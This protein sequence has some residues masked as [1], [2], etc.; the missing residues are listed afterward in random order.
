MSSRL[1]F[2]ALS[3]VV[4]LS[5]YCANSQDIKAGFIILTGDQYQYGFIQL[6]STLNW[7]EECLFTVQQGKPYT[8]YT[9]D[10]ILGYGVIDGIHFITKEVITGE[11]QQK[12]F[13]KREIEDQIALYTFN[14]NRFFIEK[15]SFVELTDT[16]YKTLLTEALKSCKG[17]LSSIKRTHFDPSGIQDLLFKYKRCIDPE[18]VSTTFIRFQFDVM[19]GAEFSNTTFSGGR[20]PLDMG[21]SLTDKTLFSG[22]VS[23]I[24]L[25]KKSKRPSF[26][27][28]L[29]YFS[30][31]LYKIDQSIASDYS[32]IDKINLDYHEL[33]MP[34]AFQ[35]LLFKKE[36]RVMPYAKVGIL[37]PFT[38]NSTF[39]WESE[40]EFTSS[41][42]YERY[43]LPQKLKQSFRPTISVGAVFNLI[44]DVRNVLELSYN[45]GGGKLDDGSNRFTVNSNQFVALLG[46]RF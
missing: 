27:T 12:Y 11:A 40:K 1:K 32:S 35:Y 28:G 25:F 7:Y 2:M 31:N 34:I 23:A 30:Q 14:N 46:F 29:Y 5:C 17:M 41:V 45:K 43:D 36:K 16:N 21:I 4:C 19:A 8:K 24:I 10:Q 38:I 44:N 9:P 42:F 18:S 3:W 37:I 22:G 13:L 39:T 26:V 6:D 15:D 20:A 33:L